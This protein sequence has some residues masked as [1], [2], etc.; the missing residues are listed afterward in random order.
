MFIGQTGKKSYTVHVPYET[1]NIDVCV[2]VCVYIYIQLLNSPI[3]TPSLCFTPVCFAPFFLTPHDKFHHPRSQQ[4]LDRWPT[5]WT[6]RP[7]R[8]AFTNKIRFCII[9]V[10]DNGLISLT[11]QTSFRNFSIVRTNKI[12]NVSEEASSETLCILLVGTMEKVLKEVYEVSDN[13]IL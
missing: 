1:L 7:L 2:C 9:T 10:L 11:S 13:K 6:T 12:H 3:Y 4:A 5:P 8:S